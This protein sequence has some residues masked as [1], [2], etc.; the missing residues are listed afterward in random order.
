[1]PIEIRLYVQAA[2]LLSHQEYLVNPIQPSTLL[3]TNH[4]LYY[5]VVPVNQPLAPPSGMLVSHPQV[6]NRATM[7]APSTLT[8]PNTF[9][10]TK[11][12]RRKLSLKSHRPRGSRESIRRTL[13]YR[14]PAEVT[15]V[16]RTP[17]FTI[18]QSALGDPPGEAMMLPLDTSS[19]TRSSSHF[20]LSLRCSS[21]YLS[22][23]LRTLR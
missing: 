21:S 20:A 23:S 18:A 12:L 7:T 22:R 5:S 16:A 6:R 17:R 10:N 2:G 14:C 1:M 19:P 3:P 15:S 9:M 8:P 13:V 11:P 4:R